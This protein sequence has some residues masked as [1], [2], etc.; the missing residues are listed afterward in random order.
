MATRQTRSKG[1]S[2]V[3]FCDFQDKLP[4]RKRR[5]ALNNLTEGAPQTGLGRGK[6]PP[7]STLRPRALTPAKSSEP[8]SSD[9]NHSPPQQP[10]PRR[11]PRN[12]NRSPGQSVAPAGAAAQ[13]ADLT[14]T[15]AQRAEARKKLS[16]VTIT[17]Q[18]VGLLDANGPD[19]APHRPEDFWWRTRTLFGL[20]LGMDEYRPII[21]RLEDLD[22]LTETIQELDNS[23]TIDYEPRATLGIGNPV[24]DPV[25]REL[26]DG[27][28]A[29][30]AARMSTLR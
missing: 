26:K 15:R 6:R 27:N 10:Q 7:G 16:A 25:C 17:S 11:S 13:Q 22:Y 24:P 28:P 4:K 14:P 3:D 23:V 8:P 9:S 12:S 18:G 2:G 20:P 21:Y 1:S 5:G 30:R 19:L 29:R